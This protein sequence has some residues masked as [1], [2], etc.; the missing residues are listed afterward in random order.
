MSASDD[1]GTIGKAVVYCFAFLGVLLLMAP[2]ILINGLAV[3]L[4][5][6]WFVVPTFNLPEVSILLGAGLS[7]V[8]VALRPIHLKSCNDGDVDNAVKWASFAAPYLAPLF[9]IGTGYVLKGF[10]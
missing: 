4:L 6:G 7:T 5:W 9:L 10:M 1:F 8:A 3:S 2:A